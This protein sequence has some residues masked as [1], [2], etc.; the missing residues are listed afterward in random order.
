MSRNGWT[1]IETLCVV[2]I[3]GILAALAIPFIRQASTS[4][5][6]PQSAIKFEEVKGAL[7]ASYDMKAVETVGNH[8]W[9]PLYIGTDTSKRYPLPSEY[10][11]FILSALLAFE[12]EHPELEVTNWKI[13][14]DQGNS[15]PDTGSPKIYGLWIDHEPK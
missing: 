10:R 4:A 14:R 1:L 12:K 11:A 2:A 7:T 13:E 6:Q 5:P 15:M 3:V 8:S 9:M